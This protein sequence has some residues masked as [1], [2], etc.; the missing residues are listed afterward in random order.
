MEIKAKLLKPYTEEQRLDFIVEQNHD[1]GYKLKE[2]EKELQAWGYTTKEITKAREEQFNKDFFSTSLGYIRREVT[3]ANGDSKDFLSDLLPTIAMGIQLGQ[4]VKIIA[5]NKPD[6]FSEEIT[7]WTKYQHN[8]LVT[9]QFVQEC[10]VQ[11][12][13]DFGTVKS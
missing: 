8:E 4:P 13:N 12:Q 11:L 6:D 5:Y 2:T 10:L 7:D 3:M 1:K 9:P